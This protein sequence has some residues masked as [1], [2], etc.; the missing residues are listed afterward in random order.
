[1]PMNLRESKIN[2]L[3]SIKLGDMSFERQLSESEADFFA[4]VAQ[5]A[6]ENYVQARL[7]DRARAV[8]EHST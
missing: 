5:M 2:G 6:L 4:D 1:M 8:T 7:Q 3:I